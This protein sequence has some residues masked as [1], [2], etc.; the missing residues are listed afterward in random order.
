MLR[1]SWTR[2]TARYI[3]AGVQAQ[4][5]T[6]TITN[7]N[8]HPISRRANGCRGTAGAALASSGAG[9]AATWAPSDAMRPSV[10]VDCRE[11]GDYALH[12]VL[13]SGLFGLDECR[14]MAAERAGVG[15]L[16]QFVELGE[17]G[18]NDGDL[19]RLLI[20]GELGVA[21]DLKKVFVRLKLARRKQLVIG[22][23]MKRRPDEVCEDVPRGLD[24]CF[25]AD[26]AVAH[27]ECVELALDGWIEC[28]SQHQRLER[29]WRRGECGGRPPSRPARSAGSMP[30]LLPNQAT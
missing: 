11:G 8:S 29:K 26:M 14:H 4:A 16:L 30:D 22:R 3:S 23:G 15:L 25:T 5:S 17:L 12:V 28:L 13:T 27:Q 18:L 10:R 9:A 21:F 19:L 20:V 6:A 24:F 7:Q 1:Q 2:S